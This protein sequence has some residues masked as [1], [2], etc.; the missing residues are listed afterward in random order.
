MRFGLAFHDPRNL[1]GEPDIVGGDRLA[2]ILPA[3]QKLAS[4]DR[5]HPVVVTLASCNSGNVGSVAGAGAGAGAG[6]SVAHALHES[7]IPMVVAGQFP[8]SFS[9]SALMV[10]A[11]YKGLL[12]GEDPRVTLS[13]LRRS[14]HSQ[15]PDSHDWVSITAYASL[16]PG[17]EKRLVDVQIAQTMRAINVAMNYADQFTEKLSTRRRKAKESPPTTQP[18]FELTL[19]F[20]KIDTAKKQL[21]TLVERTEEQHA[22]LYGLLASTEKRRGEV[23]F[24]VHSNQQ[25]FGL[26]NKNYLLESKK[27]LLMAR[28]FYWDAFLLDRSNSWGVVQYLSLELVLQRTSI[29]GM[30]TKTAERGERNAV[31]SLW[32]LAHV[33][34]LNDLSSPEAK[35]VEWGYGNLVEL[36]LLGL[37]IPETLSELGDKRVNELRDRATQRAVDLVNHA[38]PDSFE[39]YS[40]RRQVLRY[41]EWYSQMASLDSLPNAAE[42][43]L[44]KLPETDK[45]EWG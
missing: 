21:E 18:K 19:A 44:L 35:H 11:L 37:L 33:L 36:Y 24:F 13:E 7:G 12:W 22:R 39:V 20:E 38:G 45:R 26:S 16:P 40:T 29:D 1:H 23:Y 6:S 41:I 30:T 4:D 5:T 17:F 42:E 34:S 43:V 32:T 25:T 31:K 3:A 2:T 27:S 15:L 14:L 8:L 10:E 28:K 9:G